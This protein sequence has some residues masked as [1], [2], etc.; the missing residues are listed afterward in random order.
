MGY[1]TALLTKFLG[2]IDAEYQYFGIPA[3]EIVWRS[4]EKASILDHIA[5]PYN[6]HHDFPVIEFT[7]EQGRTTTNHWIRRSYWI[8]PPPP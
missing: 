8:Q 6:K 5:S 1:P 4:Y 7:S 2:E 3:K